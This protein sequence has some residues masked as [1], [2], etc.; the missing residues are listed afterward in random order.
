[1]GSVTEGPLLD[2][3]ASLPTDAQRISEGSAKQ[4]QNCIAL[5]SSA[6]KNV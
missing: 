3:F 4:L 2:S 1:M 5:T 6:Q